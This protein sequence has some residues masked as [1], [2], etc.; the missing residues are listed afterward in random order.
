MNVSSVLLT[1]HHADSWQNILWISSVVQ[2]LVKQHL[3]YP[4]LNCSS[5]KFL[6]PSKIKILYHEAQNLRARSQTGAHILYI[7]FVI[8]IWWSSKIWGKAE[9]D[10]KVCTIT[11]ILSTLFVTYLTFQPGKTFSCVVY[12]QNTHACIL[13]RILCNFI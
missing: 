8:N 1:P 9:K 4:F 10:T 7:G 5:H 3:N 13:E 11:T 12:V 6:I 2:T